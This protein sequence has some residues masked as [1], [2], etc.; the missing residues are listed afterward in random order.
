MRAT[1]VDRLPR[2]EER[3]AFEV[4]WDGVRALAYVYDG[5]V[6]VQSRSGRDV[7]PEY[8]ELE[9]LSGLDRCVLDGE[10]V[11][12]DPAGR[13]RFELLQQ[14][15][16][17]RGGPAGAQRRAT[18]PIVY[19]VFD[20]LYAGGDSCMGRPYEE[21]RATLADLD[22]PGGIVQVPRHHVGEG[23][24]LL[25]ATR[26][27]ELEGLVAKRLGSLYVSGQRSRHWL[28]LKNFRRQELVVGG[29]M[30][31]EGGR[32]GR[33]GALLVGYYD[34]GELRYAGRVGSGFSETELDRLGH[35]LAPLAA[36]SSPF[37]DE[38]ALP[39]DVKRSGRFVQPRLVAEVAFTEWTRSGTLRA[40]SYKGLRDDISPTD[41]RRET[42]EEP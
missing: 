30:P 31:G 22:M 40:P 8:P 3:W 28:K 32:R 36:R 37:A 41:V 12:L 10:V 21:R 9:A 16:N 13:P 1:P 33:L 14:R 18:T 38:P 20:V 35:L 4:K 42:A 6:V 27:N 26:A 23:S 25:A 17:I 5:R 7:S 34:G 19:L 15:I 2:D 39:A 11:A 29:W 24:A